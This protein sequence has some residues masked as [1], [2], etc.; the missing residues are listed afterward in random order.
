MAVDSLD[1]STKEFLRTDEVP[2]KETSFTTIDDLSKSSKTDDEKLEEMASKTTDKAPDSD[3]QTEGIAKDVNISKSDDEKLSDSIKCDTS[4]ENESVD[5]NA[6]EDE[7]D[8]IKK[9][10]GA[11]KNNSDDEAECSDSALSNC[12]TRR[13]ARIKTISEI[14]T[15]IQEAE[16]FFEVCESDELSNV[17]LR[18]SLCRVS[19]PEDEVC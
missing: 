1:N 3:A 16:D 7:E 13:S 6:N 18:D 12:G 17:E 8:E 10:G 19:S 15:E 11:S 5:D 14:K 9:E 2:P 4:G